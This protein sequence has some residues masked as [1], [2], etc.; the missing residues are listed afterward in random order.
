MVF[1]QTK[2]SNSNSVKKQNQIKEQT[3]N[4]FCNFT[5]ITITTGNNQVLYRKAI[6]A[7]IENNLC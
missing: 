1:R 5:F 3:Y 4:F 2:D 6:L 7:A